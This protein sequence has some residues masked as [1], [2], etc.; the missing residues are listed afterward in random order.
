MGLS[1]FIDEVSKHLIDSFTLESWYRNSIE[2]GTSDVFPSCLARS[3]FFICGGSF[4]NVA[5]V[6]LPIRG[7]IRVMCSTEKF[8]LTFCFLSSAWSSPLI[9]CHISIY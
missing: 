1:H 7:K 6:T 2:Y 3:N 8:S 4:Y 5:R 9:S